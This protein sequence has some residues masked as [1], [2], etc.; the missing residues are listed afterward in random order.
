MVEG[1]TEAEIE[2]ENAAV[3]ELYFSFFHVVTDMK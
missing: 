1:E 2:F 3:S